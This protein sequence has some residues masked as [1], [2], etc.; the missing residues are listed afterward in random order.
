MVIHGEK[1]GFDIQIQSLEILRISEFMT[2]IV[3]LRLQTYDKFVKLQVM[4][5]K[6]YLEP[7]HSENFEQTF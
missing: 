2:E 3:F 4:K 1:K 7:N 5:L 6:I